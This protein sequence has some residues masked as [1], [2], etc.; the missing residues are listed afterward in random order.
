MLAAEESRHL[1]SAQIDARNGSL[2]PGFLAH[3]PSSALE[4]LTPRPVRR[5]F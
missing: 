1:C 3:K 2:D 4:I 5:F